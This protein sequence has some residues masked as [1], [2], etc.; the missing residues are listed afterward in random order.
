MLT[1]QMEMRAAPVG[2]LPVGPSP[3]SLSHTLRTVSSFQWTKDVV[4]YK[5]SLCVRGDASAFNGSVQRW[6]E[7][8][9]VH[10]LHQSLLQGGDGAEV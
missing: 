8:E 3:L 1:E 10:V 5:L 6:A 4:G 9:V 2:R 7:C